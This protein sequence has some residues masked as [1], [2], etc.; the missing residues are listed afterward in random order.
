[1]LD[2]SR[3]DNVKRRGRKT[4]AACP[5]CREAGQDKVGDH[6]VIFE[7]GKFGCVLFP[8]ASGRDHRKR[9]AELVGLPDASDGWK[10][11]CG[12]AYL[13]HPELPVMKTR[14]LGRFGRLFRT[15]HVCG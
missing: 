6:L 9:I 7:D 4:T 1:M 5:A 15:L 14:K 12:T 2:L 11:P 10:R 8:G 13:R 3:L